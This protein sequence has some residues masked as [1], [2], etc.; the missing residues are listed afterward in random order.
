MTNENRWS[1][2]IPMFLIGCVVVNVLVVHVISSLGGGCL[3]TY[4]VVV[5]LKF[6]FIIHLNFPVIRVGE[7]H[8]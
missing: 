6:P 8:K 5:P 7:K 3:Y 1:H 2:N 4:L